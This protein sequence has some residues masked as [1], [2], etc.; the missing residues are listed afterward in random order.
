MDSTA[1]TATTVDVHTHMDID[2]DVAKL[3]D[4]EVRIRFNTR[5]RYFRELAAKHGVQTESVDALTVAYL[6]TFIGVVLL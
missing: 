3:P 4:E 2:G 5:Y 6:S 1:T